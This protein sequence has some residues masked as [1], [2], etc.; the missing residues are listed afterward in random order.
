MK[1]S[2]KIGIGILI[3]FVC[4]FLCTICC[5]LLFSAGGLAFIGTLLN[6]VPTPSVSGGG[7]K[8]P[9]PVG[10]EVKYNEISVKLIDFEFSGSYK[11]DYDMDENPPEGAKFLWIHIN[12]RNDGNN[13]TYSPSLSEFT[14]TY[15]GKQINTDSYFS[16]RPGYNEFESGQIFPGISREGWL[17]FT[18]PNAAQANQIIVIY[19]PTQL[20]SDTYYSWKLGP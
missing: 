19:K 11:S 9:L 3:G 8:S 14:L 12:A 4:V 13:S 1:D 7:S 20:F 5:F 16:S 17:R 6:S 2:M 15:Q 10:S 18:V